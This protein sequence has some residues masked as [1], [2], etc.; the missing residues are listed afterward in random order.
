MTRLYPLPYIKT[1]ASGDGNAQKGR[2]R[3]PNG[4]PVRKIVVMGASAGGIDALCT[5][6]KALPEGLPAAVLVVQHLAQG[7]K[8]RLPEILGRGTRLDVREAEDGMVLESGVVYVAGPGRHL[9]VEGN[10]ILL[11]DGVPVRHVKPAA[12]VLFR[13]AAAAWGPRTVGVILSGT[14]KDGAEGCRA[15]K[16]GGGITIAED[17]KTAAFRYMPEAAVRTGKVDHVLPVEAIGDW[18]S[19]LVIGD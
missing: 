8:T 9:M 11:G 3:K 17:P 2:K 13:S 5:V 4:L 10:R 19:S 16:E 1:H 14:G 15:V 18:I 12:D 6:L 7:H